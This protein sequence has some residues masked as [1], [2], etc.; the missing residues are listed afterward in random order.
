M[1]K[2]LVCLLLALALCLSLAGCGGVSYGVNAIMTLV[3]QDY[4]MA[5]RNDDMVYYYVVAALEELNAEGTINELC[6]KWLGS[7]MVSFGR[8]ADALSAYEP[9]EPRTFIIGVDENSFPFAY[10]DNGNYW[11]FDVELA[12]RMCEKLG[13]TLQVHVVEKE[14]VYIELYSGNIDCAWGG[15]ALPEKDIENKRYTV[16]GPYVHNDIVIASRDGSNIWN[17]LQLSGRK[18]AMCTTAGGHG[19]AAERREGG[20]PS[21]ADHASR[22]RHDRVLQLSLRRKVRSDP[23]RQ[24]GD[25]VL[26]FALSGKLSMK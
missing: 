20:E 2:K 25:R 9:P 21:R 15:L 24:H 1:R 18:M 10:G 19:G 7:N 23:D 5:F 22:R 26:Q 16:Y 14:N 13:W 4:S 17:S 11:G 8:K 3:E 6:R 12:T